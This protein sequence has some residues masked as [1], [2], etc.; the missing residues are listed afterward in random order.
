VIHYVDVDIRHD[1]GPIDSHSTRPC[2]T[3]VRQIYADTFRRIYCCP[4]LSMFLFS[5]YSRPTCILWQQALYNNVWHKMSIAQV[6]ILDSVILK[7]PPKRVKTHNHEPN[8]QVW[9]E[10]VP[11]TR[12]GRQHFVADSKT[13]RR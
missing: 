10:H 7:M 13:C 9:C 2:A 8:F 12:M 11:T 3:R 6:L 1:V 4:L 5:S